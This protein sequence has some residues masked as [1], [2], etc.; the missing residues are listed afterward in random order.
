MTSAERRRGWAGPL[1][2]AAGGLA[3]RRGWAAGRPGIAGCGGG[4]RR[5]PAVGQ[6]DLKKKKKSTCGKREREKKEN[7]DIER[8]RMGLWVIFPALFLN[9]CYPDNFKTIITS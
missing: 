3:A 1:A 9:C 5:P 8:I 2:Q 7:Y 4:G 6:S